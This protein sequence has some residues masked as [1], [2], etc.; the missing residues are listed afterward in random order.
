M[1][2][3]TDDR[4]LQPFGGKFPSLTV[5]MGGNDYPITFTRHPETGVV[6]PSYDLQMMTKATELDDAHSVT[7]QRLIQDNLPKLKQYDGYVLPDGSSV[8]I[9]NDIPILE[10]SSGNRLLS[11]D[12]DMYFSD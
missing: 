3:Q 1:L 12:Q 8:R 11:G 2:Q 6:S 10:T 4:A 9:V 5:S 7:R